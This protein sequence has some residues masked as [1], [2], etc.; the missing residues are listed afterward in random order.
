MHLLKQVYEE[1][2][3]AN[4]Y[5]RPN[6]EECKEFNDDTRIGLKRLFY[7]KCGLPLE[8]ITYLKRAISLKRVYQLYGMSTLHKVPLAW[9]HIISCVCGELEG[10]STWL[11]YQLRKLANAVPTYIHDSHEADNSLK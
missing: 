3:S 9:S 11:D 8:E 10:V 6:E 2:L 7:A 1:H 5:F 4:I